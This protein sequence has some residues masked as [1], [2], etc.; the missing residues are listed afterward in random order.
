[1]PLDAPPGY[2]ARRLDPLRDAPSVIGLIRAHY[3]DVVVGME[4]GHLEP[5]FWGETPHL[6]GIVVHAGNGELA[7]FLTAQYEPRGRTLT[8]RLVVVAPAHRGAGLGKL[9]AGHATEVLARELGAEIALSYATL[10]HSMSQAILEDTGYVLVGLVPAH[11]RD[12]VSPGEVRR[13]WEALYA[14]RF[15]ADAE[16]LAPNPDALLPAAARMLAAIRW[17]GG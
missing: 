17:P 9:L 4:S 5:G 12:M 2:A 15:V 8:G 14:K 13:V 10:K 7:A 1:M 11:D 3:P 16:I 6:H